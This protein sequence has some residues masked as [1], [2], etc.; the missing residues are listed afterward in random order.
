MKK[1]RPFMQIYNDFFEQK[2]VDLSPNATK[3]YLA[4]LSRYNGKN[5]GNISFS[6]REMQHYLGKGKSTAK[7]AFDE[8]LD[9]DIIRVAKNSTFDYKYQLARTWFMTAIKSKKKSVHNIAQSV[10]NI[11]YAKAR[12]RETGAK[13]KSIKH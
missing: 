11:G 3:A 1:Y 12:G 7:N 5:N 4:I 13:N 9:H 10:Q 8:L 6:C 2:L